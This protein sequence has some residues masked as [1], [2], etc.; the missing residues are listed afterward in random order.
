[1]L[2]RTRRWSWDNK[3]PSAVEEMLQEDG[4]HV[5]ESSAAFGTTACLTASRARGTVGQRILSDSWGGVGPKFWQS[6]GQTALWRRST[7]C[8][9]ARWSAVD[10]ALPS[11]SSAQ[12]WGARGGAVWDAVAR[13]REKYGA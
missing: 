7:A 10:E 9:S 2:Q 12:V 3:D 4:V 13:A 1:M 6:G 8:W 5:E 11:A